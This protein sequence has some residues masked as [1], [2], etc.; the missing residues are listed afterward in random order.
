MSCSPANLTE[1]ITN[2]CD[3]KCKL[4]TDYPSQGITVTGISG[5]DSTT[6]TINGL[7]NLNIEFNFSEYVVYNISFV[8]KSY[9]RYGGKSVSAE[10]II[11]HF[12]RGGVILICIPIV[13]GFSSSDLDDVFSNAGKGNE[14]SFDLNKFIP[15]QP[16]YSYK[17]GVGLAEQC[18]GNQAGEVIVFQKR[19]ALT[20]LQENIDF[21]ADSRH[22]VR[23]NISDGESISFS[24]NKPL[25]KEHDTAFP[26][27]CE[28]YEDTE[29]EEVKKR[30]F[31]SPFVM[32]DIDFKEWTS[33]VTLQIILGAV[34]LYVLVKFLFFITN[35][36]FKGAARRGSGFD[37]T[38]ET[39]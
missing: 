13:V 31:R 16:Y 26:I 39:M 11:T 25:K 32:S 34:I 3:L 2:S 19:H 14:S 6:L 4:I 20:L 29:M 9:H 18:P 35:I 7:S 1:N 15:Q 10:M 8:K 33:N 36:G 24:K 27:T 30:K 23:F 28:P 37:S 17:G 5:G 12:G 22:P 38:M 21:I